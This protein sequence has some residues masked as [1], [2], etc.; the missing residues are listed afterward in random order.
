MVAASAQIGDLV[1]SALKR[2]FGVK[3]SPALIPGHGG[4]L[5]RFDSYFLCFPLAYAYL[6]FLQKLASPV[7]G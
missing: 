2:D 4:F 7:P 5:D 3:D 1:Q 6:L